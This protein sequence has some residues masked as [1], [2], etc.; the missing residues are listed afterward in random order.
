MPG[1]KTVFDES[2]LINPVTPDDRATASWQGCYDNDE[3]GQKLFF[4]AMV[5]GISAT[6]VPTQVVHFARFFRSD[7]HCRPPLAVV[8]IRVIQHKVGV[9][10]AHNSTHLKPGA[11]ADRIKHDEEISTH[12]S[13]DWQLESVRCK[14]YEE[15]VCGFCDIRILFLSCHS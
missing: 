11:V 13:N 9:D 14:I 1:P 6:I 4:V 2:I 3:M 8:W 15:E 5:L 10:V 7:I 12:D